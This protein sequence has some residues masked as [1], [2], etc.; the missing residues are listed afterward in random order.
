MKANIPFVKLFQT[1]DH[2]YFFDVN[3]NS[4][5]RINEIVFHKIEKLIDGHVELEQDVDIIKLK[6]RGYLRCNNE[7]IAIKHSALDTVEEYMNGNLRQLILQV[8]QNCNLRCRYCVYSGSYVNRTHTK[9]RMSY[10]VAK[11][12]V[13][14]YFARNTS[15]DAGII[16]FY[17]GE[18]L[19]EIELI[20][21]IVE[22]SENLYKGKELRLNLTTNATLLTNEIA[23][24]LYEHDFNLTI[25]LDGPEEVH[26]RSRVFADNETGTFQYVMQNLDNFLNRHPDFASNISFNAVLDTTNDFKCSSQFFTYDFMKKAVVTA[27]TL[28]ENGSKQRVQYSELFD[29]NYR[30]EL[31]KCYLKNIGRLNTK[32]VSKLAD[33]QVQSLKQDIHE[34]IAAPYKRGMICH[35]SGPCIAGAAR[36]FVTVDGVFYPCERVNETCDAYMIGNLQDGFYIDKI[37]KLL[38]VGELTSEQC[39]N[40]WAVEY[41]NSCASGIDEGDKLC[42][43]KRLVRCSDIKKGCELRMIEYCT[44]REMGCKFE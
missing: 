39:K 32:Y 21:K 31:F 2:Y 35:P 11:Q 13:D 42:P 9:K 19:L 24:F 12:A 10:D 44:L 30:Y 29:I 38:N 43:E 16:S 37:K 17:G 34:K 25:S 33:N 22:Y 6:N 26:N 40:C 36:L 27:T 23:D 4:I 20:K 3:T 7:E 8:T 28:N 1:I 5:I 14:F 41:C 18:P 15:K